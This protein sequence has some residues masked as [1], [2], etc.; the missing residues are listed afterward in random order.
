M[1]Y[2]NQILNR[3]TLLLDDQNAESNFINYNN[4]IIF[5]ALR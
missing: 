4:F 5:S 2:G 1:N 3:N